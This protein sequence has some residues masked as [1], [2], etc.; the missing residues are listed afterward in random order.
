MAD[1]ETTEPTGKTMATVDSK[2]QKLMSTK[3]GGQ[4]IH[5]TSR[6]SDTCAPDCPFLKGETHGDSHG[7]PMCYANDKLGRPS[8]FQMADRYGV[9]DTH[10]A[11]EKIRSAR[12]KGAAVRHLV[13]GDVAGKNDDYIKEA[14]NLH[15]L[16]KDLEGWGYTHNWRQMSPKD[17]EGWTLNASTE[18]A[19]QA[20]E[21]IGKGWQ[22]V[23]ES[24][25]DNDVSTAVT[26]QRIAGRNVVTCPNQV[27]SGRVTCADCQ[28]CRNNG[29]NRP[30]VQFIAHGSS[31]KKHVTG[32]INTARE[33]EATSQAGESVASDDSRN[34]AFKTGF[35]DR[36]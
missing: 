22:A 4:V 5:T 25:P 30:I 15:A 6:T 11:M 18:T 34:M 24:T 12:G 13:S 26:G 16:R 28:L 2:N 36:D 19:S 9:S 32:A 14:N 1:E 35:S 21:A 33:A 31:S 10:A 23:I 3:P 8:I 7:V 29:E 17:A 20:A 27:T